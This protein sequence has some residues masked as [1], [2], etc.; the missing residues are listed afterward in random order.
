MR[1]AKYTLHTLLYLSFGSFSLILILEMERFSSLRSFFIQYLP[2]LIGKRTFLS[3][4]LM[5]ICASSII[6]FIPAFF[7]YQSRF[8]NFLKDMSLFYLTERLQFL[9][10]LGKETM[11]FINEQHLNGKVTQY[12]MFLYDYVNQKHL[13]KWIIV[14]SLFKKKKEFTMFDQIATVCGNLSAYYQQRILY[15][16]RILM[17]KQTLQIQTENDRKTTYEEIERLE[18]Y[19]LQLKKEMPTSIRELDKKL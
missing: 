9:D 11:E 18:K 19:I 16:Q 15:H 1:F 13:R 12:T 7:D 17:L 8:E 2:F 5:G 4:F 6:S 3:N 10:H 14:Q